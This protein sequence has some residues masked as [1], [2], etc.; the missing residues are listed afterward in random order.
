MIS[1]VYCVQERMPGASGID[2]RP[3]G[4]ENG[5]HYRCDATLREDHSQLRMGHAP[6]LL[7]VLNNTALGVLARKGVTNVAE[8]RREFAYQVDTALHPLAR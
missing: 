3:L 6:H 4:L 8:A 7:A 1:I 5:L 2:A